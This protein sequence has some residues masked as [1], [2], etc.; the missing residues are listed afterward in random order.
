[1][2]EPNPTPRLV[3]V[4]VNWNGWRDT[5]E[6]LDSLRLQDYPN[7]GVIVVDNGS[8]D[9]SSARIR[10]AHPWITF[11]QLPVNLGF[12]SGC[13]AGTRIAYRQG[14]DLIW[15]LNNDTV[16]PPETASTIVRTALARPEAGAIGC[17]LHY[18]HDPSQVQA[19]GGG[20]INLISG[21]VSHF[22]APASFVPENTFFTGA[23]LTLP[24]RI[25]ESVGIFFEG[26]FM[27]CDDADLCLR[28]HRAGFPLVMAEDTAILHKEGASSPKRSPL[29]DQFVTTSNM[30]M[31]RRHAP[32]PA[33]SI[34][35][36]LLFRLGNR[37]LH[38][39]WQ[40]VA[41]V[42]RGIRIFFAERH[43]SFTDRL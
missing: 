1:M 7:L 6:C 25:C 19:W 31:L 14:A 16:A 40:N 39:E 35:I 15:L 29:I 10:A 24:R 8:T 3:C 41:A 33:F 21:F 27:Y 36:Y 12:P 4:L 17:V 30:R 32:V 13:N 20:R 2:A 23:S 22:H 28:I 26:F 9:D 43:R 38:R 5:L 34:A 42:C 37:L 18:M 11:E